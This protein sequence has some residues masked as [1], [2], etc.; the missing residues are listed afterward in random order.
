MARATIH[1]ISVTLKEWEYLSN[2]AHRSLKWTEANG[3]RAAALAL[4]KLAAK[5]TEPGEQIDRDSF[6]LA[7]NRVELRLL[8]KKAKSELTTLTEH[9]LPGYEAK[10]AEFGVKK[11]TNHIEF[12]QQLI[13]KMEARL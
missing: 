6:V 9:V 11:T 10:R 13:Q 7:I 4:E 12:L 2:A 1:K 3:E 5:L 8:I